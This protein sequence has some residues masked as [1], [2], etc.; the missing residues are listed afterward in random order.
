MEQKILNKQDI[1]KEIENILDLY[2]DDIA[3]IGYS[4]FINFKD[5]GNIEIKK[6]HY[7]GFVIPNHCNC[8]V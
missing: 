5:F 6:N 2:N 3:G 1:L 7:S 4:I 8:T